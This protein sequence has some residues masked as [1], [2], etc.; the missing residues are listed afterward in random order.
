M[1]FI[2]TMHKS[3]DTAGEQPLI[4]E[5]HGKDLVETSGNKLKQLVLSARG[6]LAARNVEPGDRVA[7]I[8]HNS[9]R[10]AAADLAILGAGAIC[11]PMYDR[12]APREL[13]GMLDNC[14]AKLVLVDTDKLKGELEAA[15][16]H[17][18]RVVTF[19][20]VFSHGHVFA[21][22]RARPAGDFVTMIYT[23][24]TS[25]E[26][27]GVLYTVDNV[28]YMLAQTIEGIRQMVAPR[29]GVD[30]VFHYLPFCFAGS[31]IQLWSQ[32]AR[33]NPLMVSTDLNNLVVELG[34]A[35]PHYFLNVP[36]LIERIRTGVGNKLK[37][38]G[39]IAFALYSRAVEAYQ[40]EQKGQHG[41]A[42]TLALAVGKRVVFSKIRAQIGKNLEFLIC[43]SAPL[44]EETQRWFSMI[45]IPVYQVYGLTET[46]AIVTMDKKG[47]ARPGYVGRPLDG[48][49]LKV[50]EEGE[51]LCR[52]PNIF[53][54]YWKRPEAT[55]KS[56]QDG[57]FHTGDMAELT[58]DQDL[59]IVGRLKDLLVPES[60]HNVAPGPLEEKLSSLLPGAQVMLV[61]H[62]RPYLS[63]IF[64]GPA[65]P[66]AVQSAIDQLN[67]E[68]P[69]Y[70]RVRKFY[71]APEPFSVENGLLT[72]NQKLK[73][74][75]VEQHYAAQIEGLYS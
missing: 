44:S 26:P 3:L 59:R 20:E 11:V 74:N 65:A 62:A 68:L 63:A 7:L 14:E 24:G 75:A 22:P 33:A 46:T 57:W 48:V 43:G 6:L 49:E 45:G 41:V 8:A 23:S 4:I 32:L 37:E 12:Q 73:R 21:E 67:E 54:A 39:G 10:W 28:D 64:A 52:G 35:Q 40:R 34:T 31:R 61:G 18:G 69:H 27:K 56:L 17:R 55:A 70:R 1:S 58:P 72:A 66:D 47:T 15:W 36:T 25:G 5:V 38:R 71:L 19:D 42:D 53:P 16:E 30:R 13:A 29:T 2:E 60:G 51:L 50:S 9:A